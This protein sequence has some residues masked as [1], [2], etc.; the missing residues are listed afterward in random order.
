MNGESETRGY[1]TSGLA[2]LIFL[3]AEEVEVGIAAHTGSVE[4]S[5]PRR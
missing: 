5:R 3:E 2:P 1:R 4:P